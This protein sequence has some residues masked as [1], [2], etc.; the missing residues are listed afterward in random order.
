VNGELKE[1]VLWFGELQTANRRATVIAGEP[2]GEAEKSPWSLTEQED[3]GDFSASP[4][5]SHEPVP[6][7]DYLFD[8]DA[9]VV[10]AGLAGQLA[11]QLRLSPID[12]TVAMFTGPELVQSPFVTPYRVEFAAKFHIGKLRDHLREHRVGRVTIVKRGS[13]ID[14]EDVQ[15]KLKL[16]GSE[17]RMVILTRAT[18]E[19]TMIVGSRVMSE[20]C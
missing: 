1:C 8:P 7:G 16:D 19:Q 18:G 3:H 14:A 2:R 15:R 20:K 9:A 5:G 17:H 4:R 12:W 6:V 13:M 10:R 11:E